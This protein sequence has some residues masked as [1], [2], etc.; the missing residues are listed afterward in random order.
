[1]Y[2]RSDM[3]SSTSD[4]ISGSSSTTRTDPFVS[5]V[6]MVFPFTHPIRGAPSLALCS[7][8]GQVGGDA[9]KAPPVE[10]CI[11]SFR[12]GHRPRRK[13]PGGV[14]TSAIG[15]EW[16]HRKAQEGRT[17]TRRHGITTKLTSIIGRK[18]V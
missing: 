5:A 2:P 18:L 17:R 7:A 15:Q 11:E 8:V 13:Q 14:G 16:R 3:M 1:A 10:F 6:T 12:P 9:I 4:P